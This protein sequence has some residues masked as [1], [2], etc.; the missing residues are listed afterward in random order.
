M[1]LKE[2]N[3]SW[4]LNANSG[5]WRKFWN[6]KIPKKVKIFMWRALSDCLP[7]KDQLRLRKVNVDP[8]CPVCNSEPETVIHSLITCPYAKCCWEATGC[9]YDMATSTNFR[10]W[11]SSITEHCSYE[12][13]ATTN[14]LAWSIWNNRN[15]IV[16]NQ[17]GLE[18]AKVVKSATLCLNQWRSAQDR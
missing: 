15:D 6:L 2:G 17:K 5:F 1:L 3:N 9:I 13:M 14:M 11:L 7:T 18:D 16:R 8:M 4:N 10:Q 12:V